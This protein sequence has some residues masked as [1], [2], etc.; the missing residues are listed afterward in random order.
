VP[1][2]EPHLWVKD[3]VFPLDDPLGQFPH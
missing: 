3:V 1:P 2:Q